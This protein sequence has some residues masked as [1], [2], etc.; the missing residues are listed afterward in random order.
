MSVYIEYLSFQSFLTILR[1]ELFF[2]TVNNRQVKTHYYIDA[3]LLGE[4]MANVFSRIFGCQFKKLEFELRYIKDNR[5]ELI[6]LRLLR[7]DLFNFQNQIINS[8][9]FKKLFN[10]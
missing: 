7:Q 3:T 9:A 2:T 5:G 6:R 1:K 4:K 10:N 8:F